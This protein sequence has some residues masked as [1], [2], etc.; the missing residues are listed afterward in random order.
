MCGTHI[1]NGNVIATDHIIRSASV[2]LADGKIASVG[3]NIRPAKSSNTIDAKGLFVSPGFIDT[4]IHGDPADILK[5]E[6]KF[7]T[8]SIIV[9]I[10][11]DSLMGGYRKIN[12]IRKFKKEDP[13][14]TSMLGIRLEGPY[15]SKIKSGAQNKQYIKKPNT[16]ELFGVIK[17][18]GGELKIIT[19]APEIKGALGLVKILK[20]KNIIASL[21]HSNATY[22]EARRGID[23]GITHATH[24]FNAM[25]GVDYAGPGAS[26]ACIF[27]DRVITEIILDLVHVRKQLFQVLLKLKGLDKTIL[28]TDSVRAEKN[29][30]AKLEG[31]VYRFQDGRIAGSN[32]TMIQ[33]L[34]N[35]VKHCNLSLPEAIRLITLNPAK[36]LGLSA[37]KGMIAKGRDADL[38]IFDKDFDVK[39]TMINGKIAYRQR[40][41]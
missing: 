41:F 30:A 8:T 32:T 16:G 37:R 20:N 39:M 23:A 38:V 33:V 27:D 11:C 3:A 1:K 5:H 9:A 14:G 21:G 13:L 22:E 12:E 10:S 36:L 2:T 17:K 24:I 31:N 4:H 28:I 25:R 34:K 6:I 15:I 26:S 18:C 35:A 7:G 29:P 40:G 19:I